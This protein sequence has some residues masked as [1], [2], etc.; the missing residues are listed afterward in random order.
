MKITP[1]R[2]LTKLGSYAFADV[3]REVEKL[4]SRGVTPIDFG[5]GDPLLPTPEF[6]R[7]ACREGVERRASEG[8]P[9]YEGTPEFR[10]AVADWTRRRFGVDLDPET[11]ITSTVGSK[12]G[13]FNFAEGFVD[14]GDLVLLPTPGYP[15]YGRGTLFAEG[16]PWVY[17]LV[18]ESGFLPD[19]GAIPDDVARRAK[20]LWINYPNAPTGRVAPASFF[21]EAAAFGRERGILVASDEA[22]S[23]IFFTDEPPHSILEFGKENVVAVHSLS[24][25]SA[26]TGY[27]VG[28]VAGDAEA[29][30]AFRK[31]KTNVDS[32]TPRFVQDAAVAAL[33]DETHVRA[34]RRDY[35]EKGDLLLAA[36]E[37][38][39]LEIC[40]PDA[41]LYI[42]Q[43]VPMEALE[44]CKRLL[45]P[46]VAVV[47]TP[48]DWISEPTA[49]G[50]NPGKG[51]V[52]FALV[53]PLEKVR[54]A[55]RRIEGMDLA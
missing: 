1:S 6:I 35:R 31:V 10:G 25:R 14:P 26:M 17:P 44:F 48:G 33:G 53:P 38:L 27:R 40:R 43:K 28:W 36:F 47:A 9:P 55:A 39:G 22:Y 37:K 13:I 41:T 50:I 21:E 4:R 3:Q 20:V 18:S 2:R 32:G 23:E 24:K 52:R 8:Y 30:A 16:E 29:V 51:H 45:S 34:M 46:E 5:V 11:E 12:E 15:P 54:E 7:Q 49:D 19:L 42:W